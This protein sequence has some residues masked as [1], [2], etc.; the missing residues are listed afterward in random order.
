MDNSFE[1]LQSSINEDPDLEANKFK[2]VSYQQSNNNNNKLER[3]PMSSQ[4]FDE[5]N[6]R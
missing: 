2:I 1:Q 3:K 4:D 6:E 5:I